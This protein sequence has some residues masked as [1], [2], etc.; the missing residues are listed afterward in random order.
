MTVLW[1]GGRGLN[2]A[3]AKLLCGEQCFSFHWFRLE[4]VNL[5]VN[6]KPTQSF[7]SLTTNAGCWCHGKFQRQCHKQSE[8][9]SQV[10]GTSL[11]LMSG[12]RDSGERGGQ[13]ET[14]GRELSSQYPHQH[15]LLQGS[16]KALQTTS[17]TGTRLGRATQFT[18][19]SFDCRQKKASFDYCQKEAG[20]TLRSAH[21]F[22]CHAR[23]IAQKF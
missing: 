20:Y 21:S 5:N 14:E 18:K 19:A 3:K 4:K 2:A 10:S 7:W 6:C 11:S 22:I 16:I 9:P 13:T 8:G 12:R 15:L 1:Q 17:H 23:A